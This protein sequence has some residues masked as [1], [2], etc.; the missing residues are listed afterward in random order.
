MQHHHSYLFNFAILDRARHRHA[1]LFLDV[2]VS[3]LCVHNIYDKPTRLKA[4][5]EIGR[6]LKPGGLLLLSD[7]KLTGEYAQQFRDMGFAVETKWGSFVTTFPP[8]RVVIG[9]KPG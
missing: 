8:L 6:V 7:Y 3:N 4:L 9:R 1:R 5:H 2:I